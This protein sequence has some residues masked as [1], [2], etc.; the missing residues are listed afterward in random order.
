MRPTSFSPARLLVVIVFGV[1]LL[2][3]ASSQP[4]GTE[5]SAPDS[6]RTGYGTQAADDVT[7]ATASVDP[8]ERDPE[9]ADDLSGLLQGSTAG[10]QVD[11]TSNGVR[12]LIR[13]MNSIH[14]D[15]TPLYVMDGVTVEP[16]F[17]GAVPVRPQD[18][19][20]ITVLKDA[21]ATAIY[22]SRGSNGVIVIETKGN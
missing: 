3:C 8:E 2:G 10:V 15:N 1:G 14:G 20:S 22:G 16:S 21:G 5:R 19:K 17:N 13:G 11:R 12:V 18:V 6:V 9:T 7:S 4:R